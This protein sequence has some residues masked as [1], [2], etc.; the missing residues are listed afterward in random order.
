[1]TLTGLD[2]S[3]HQ[4]P[5]VVPWDALAASGS[6]LYIRASYGTTVDRRVREHFAR[7]KEKGIRV[8]LYTFFRAEQAVTDQLDVFYDLAELVGY[9]PGDLAPA[10]DIEAYGKRPVEPWW[11]GPAHELTRLLVAQYNECVV[12]ITQREWSML[13]KPTWT[14]ARP[15][16]VAHY[17]S[18]PDPATPTGHP[19]SIWQYRVGPYDPNTENRRTDAKHP[20]ALDHNMA[21]AL[22]VI[23]ADNEPETKRRVTVPSIPLELSEDDWL[24]MRRARDSIVKES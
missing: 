20:Q 17:T 11:S 14:K 5:A 4:A 16:W 8:G 21:V 19:W 22:P 15:L 9:G 12:Y 7:A 13:G 18:R 10:V 23:R 3:H 24:A 1:M 6:F 2:I